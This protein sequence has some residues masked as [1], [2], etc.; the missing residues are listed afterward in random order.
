MIT[1]NAIFRAVEKMPCG[2]THSRITV[3]F[4]SFHC[5]D[6]M[7]VIPLHEISCHQSSY[8]NLIAVSYVFEWFPGIS[9]REWELQNR[10][11]IMRK[12]N[13]Q[14]E[15]TKENYDNV[16]KDLMKPFYLD[17]KFIVDIEMKYSFTQSFDPPNSFT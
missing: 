5:S 11:E 9:F 10:N 6:D 4:M 1:S 3:N 16:T 17:R 12:V 7:Q 8:L 2:Q 13:F 15:F 14:L